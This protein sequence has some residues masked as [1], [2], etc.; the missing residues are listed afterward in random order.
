MVGT[1]RFGPYVRYKGK[2]F[3]LKK[4]VDDPYAIT[5]ER[6]IELINEKNEDEKKRVLK[7]FDDIMVL[8][9][10]FGPYLTREKKNYRLP[11]GTD[12]SKL[13][14]EECIQI[15]ESSEKKQEKS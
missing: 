15:I 13:T 12:I 11:R 14:K 9:G 1:G 5:I 6:A 8:N 7:D 3:S 2:F 10:R 4:G